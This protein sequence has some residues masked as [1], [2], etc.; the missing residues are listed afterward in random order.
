M[1]EVD[2]KELASKNAGTASP[3]TPPA[4]VEVDDV[5]ENEA[6]FGRR[7][8]ASSSTGSSLSDPSEARLEELFQEEMISIQDD[9]AGLRRTDALL[10][11]AIHLTRVDSARSVD[12]AKG[13]GSVSWG[14]FQDVHGPEA[15]KNN[16][17]KRK[18]NKDYD[19]PS[20]LVDISHRDDNGK[21]HRRDSYYGKETAH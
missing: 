19:S 2:A 14:W 18:T 13:S 1:V 17:F 8:R 6:N 20:Q 21:L 15:N 9:V 4:V 16:S 5:V 3:I 11:A 10:P 12:S 7:L